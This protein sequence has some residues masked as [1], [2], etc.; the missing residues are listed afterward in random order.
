MNELITQ[1]E[2]EIIPFDYKSLGLPVHD[3]EFL[4]SKELSIKVRTSQTI[5]ENGRDLLEAKEKVGHGNFLKWVEGCFPWSYRTAKRMMEVADNFKVD[6]VANLNF[7]QTNALYILAAPSTPESAREESLQLAESGETVTPAKSKEIVIKAKKLEELA[8]KCAN[9]EAELAAKEQTTLEPALYELIPEIQKISSKIMPAMKK[10]I[11]TW[12]PDI[13][14]DWYSMYMR[15]F[16]YENQLNEERRKAQLANEKALKAIEEK[17]EALK[18][19]QSVSGTDNAQLIARHQQE[20]KAMREEYRRCHIQNCKDIE[21]RALE[22]NK[23]EIKKAYD[24]RDKAEKKANKADNDFK[25]IATEHHKLQAKV[26]TLEEQLKV[27]SPSNIDAA[28][29]ERLK[30]ILE[31]LE[32]RLIRFE[33]DRLTLDYPMNKT[34]AVINKAISVLSGFRDRTEGIVCINKIGE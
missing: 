32:N 25:V 13:Q 16:S 14:A 11:K 15:N 21:Q 24:A 29:A 5:F 2:T 18:Q 8:A 12:R 3:T 34:W 20:L 7:I 26:R 23:E 4:K 27:D 19:L 9:L 6:T 30:D 1:P 33:E 31:S 10:K 28:H 22:S 17:E